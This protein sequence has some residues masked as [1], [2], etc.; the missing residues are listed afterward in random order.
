MKIKKLFSLLLTAVM[1]LTL[2]S[3]ASKEMSDT[4]YNTYTTNEEYKGEASEGTITEDAVTDALPPKQQA[5][6]QNERKII[7]TINMT[8]QTKD[9]DSFMTHISEKIKESGGYIEQSSE[10]GNARDSE[11]NRYAELTV[12]IPS[13]GSGSFVSFVEET[14]NVTYKNLTTDDITLKY[15]DTESR[16]SALTTEKESLENLLSNA[17]K[18]DD[19]LKIRERLTDVIYELESY[20]SQLAKYDNLVEYTTVTMSVHEVE[21]TTVTEEQ[22][23]WQKIGHNLKENFEDIGNFFVALFVFTVSALPYFLIVALV[24]IIIT[25]IIRKSVKKRKNKHQSETKTEN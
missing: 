15:V 16:I 24:A 11:R 25:I 17:A 18:M 22:S 3:C 9:F 13:G 23:V 6:S 1:L 7:E 5:M 21:R 4:E 19:I 12:R 8:V 20:T 14:G 10:S 2:A